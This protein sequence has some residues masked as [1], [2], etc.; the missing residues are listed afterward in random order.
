M[1]PSNQD[2]LYFV[3]ISEAGSLTAAS[4]RL[5]IAQPSLTLA[6]QRLER[7]LGVQLFERRQR[8]IH[9]TEAGQMVLSA[10]RQITESWRALKDQVN[11]S[12]QQLAGRVTLGCHAAVAVYALPNLVLNLK[13]KFPGI[14][15]SLRHDFARNLTSAIV[16]RQIDF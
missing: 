13:N 1:L 3:A 8:G 16:D 5:G 7:E 14:E 10:S 2:L 4:T 6:M 15:L 12:K 11:E 9:I